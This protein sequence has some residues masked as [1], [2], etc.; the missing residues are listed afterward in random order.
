LFAFLESFPYPLIISFILLIF[1]AGI[2]IK[3]SG[4]LYKKPFGYLAIGLTVVVVFLG[5]ILTF[6]GVG[7]MIERSTYEDRPGGI[8]FKPFFHPGFENRHNGV[9]GRIKEIGSD[10][11]V[12]ETPSDIQTLDLSKVEK[13][14]EVFSTGSFITAIGNRVD[15]LF[16]VEKI[17]VIDPDEMPI[18][19]RGINHQF[20]EPN[21]LP[22]QFGSNFDSRVCLEGC[23]QANLNS[24]DCAAYCLPKVME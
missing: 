2:I 13:I 15:G 20:G 17:R 4:V 5:V 1:V 6:T 18:I 9:A 14:P 19:R 21:F 12:I 7:E 24:D 8:M 16:E 22:P 23:A 11:V 3:K 10:Y